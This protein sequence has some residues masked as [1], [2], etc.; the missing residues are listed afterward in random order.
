MSKNSHH[1]EEKYAS[2]RLTLPSLIFSFT[3]P[4]HTSVLTSLLLLDIGRTFGHP[5]GVTGQIRTLASFIGAISALFMGMWSVR[6]NNKSLLLMG[7]VFCCISSIG[8]YYAV[9]FTMILITYAI[10][11]LGISMVAPMTYTLVGELF[12]LEKRVS[13][14][15]WINAGDGL[16]FIIG[17]PIIGIIAGIGGWRVAFIG[18]VLPI[19]LLSFVMAVK[20]IPSPM[21]SS[22]SP[23]NKGQYMEGIRGVIA[24]HS[25][26]A[27]L[28]GA[29]LSWAGWQ[30][31][32][33]YSASFFRQQ[34]RTSTGYTSII[35]G[36]AVFSYAVGTLV[37]GQAVTRLGKR[38]ITVITGVIA[39]VFI[40]LYTNVPISWIAFALMALGCLF[41]GTLVTT[42]YSLT[43]EQLPN[44]RGTMMSLNSA[45]ARIGTSLG[46]GV[47]G[48]VLLVSGYEY[49][50]L[51]LGAMI[52]AA[53]LIYYLL[54]SDPMRSR[55]SVNEI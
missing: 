47:G 51:I 8:C 49:V 15:G 26:I 17:A 7:L 44:F 48:I 13:A 5:V 27:C 23:R 40:I 46:A 33:V 12:P 22:H 25:A 54:V 9:N 29:A 1:F 38:P 52:L 10:W 24:N 6:F 18:F 35:I 39:G 16:A 53:A 43:L 11:G 55:G 14:I 4:T 32:L 19:T 36:S 2:G 50:G 30:A 45:A 34:F 31:I 20:W 42:A 41:F 37:S 28:G 21:Q 3:T